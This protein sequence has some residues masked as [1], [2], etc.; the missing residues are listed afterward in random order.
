MNDQIGRSHVSLRFV[1]CTLLVSALTN[2][3]A[4]GDATR[5][6]ADRAPIQVIAGADQA[7]TI[8]AVLPQALV[9]EIHDSTGKILPGLT[10]RFYGGI[11]GTLFSHLNSQSFD[12]FV[13][14]DADAQG[15]AKVLVKLGAVAGIT[16]IRVD[17]PQLRVSDTITFS[18]KPGAPARFS[19]SPRDTSIKPGTSY[20]LKAQ[21]TDRYLN[22]IASAVPTLSATGVAVTPAGLVTGGNTMARARIAVSYQGL[23]DSAS[24]SVVQRLPMV[25]FMVGVTLVNTDGSGQT[26]LATTT[27]LSLGPSSVAATPNV[28]YYQGNPGYNAKIWVVQPKGTPRLLLPGETRPESWPRLSPDGTWV[29][30]VRDLT[31]LWRARLDGTGL[32]SL[33]SFTRTRIYFAPTI[34]PDGGSV[35]IEDGTGLQILDLTTRTKR[36]LSVTCPAPQYSPDGAYFACMNADGLSIVRTDGTGRRIVAPFGE[37]DRSGVDWTPDGKWLL[38]S[39]SPAMLFEVSTGAVLTLTALG[40]IGQASFVR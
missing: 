32:D 17:V 28:V 35:A 39:T 31:S 34:S 29:Y 6:S 13:L 18:V 9:V 33:T 36:T 4:G 30:F 3:C 10:V 27:D 26:S 14:E 8:D 16:K 12:T 25:A 20:T 23:S 40:P 15:R 1:C 7:D 19:I 2:A 5:A 38:V 11:E 21:T 37:P 24:V 22:P